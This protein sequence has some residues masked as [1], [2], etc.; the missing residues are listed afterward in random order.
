MSDDSPLDQP[1]TPISLEQ[2]CRA[3]A[4]HAIITAHAD[5]LHSFRAP[6]IG[7]ET[8]EIIREFAL[9]EKLARPTRVPI[10]WRLCL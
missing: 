1:V 7:E 4:I 6:E 10:I 9:G 5:E 8:A 2:L 3:L